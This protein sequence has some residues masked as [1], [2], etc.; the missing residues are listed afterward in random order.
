MKRVRDRVYN[1]IKSFEVTLNSKLQ[2]K[3]QRY[4]KTKNQNTAK[5]KPSFTKE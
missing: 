5:R 3:Y 1:V 2:T 4:R